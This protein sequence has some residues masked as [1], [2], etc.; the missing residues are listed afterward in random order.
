M[1]KFL[2]YIIIIIIKKRSQETQHIFSSCFSFACL[3]RNK[4]NNIIKVL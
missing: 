4:K 2:L 3:T 1:L